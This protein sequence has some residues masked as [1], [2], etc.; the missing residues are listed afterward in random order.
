MKT[1]HLLLFITIFFLTF[2][3]DGAIEQKLLSI[4]TTTLFVRESPS[5]TA[6]KLKMLANGTIV[7]SLEEKEHNENIDWIK[8]EYG[9]KEN[10]IR[11]WIA[12]QYTA[13]AKKVHGLPNFMHDYP[14]M[15]K[16]HKFPGNPPVKVRGIYLSM[17]SAMRG[18][19]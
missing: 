1:L 5:T 18:R 9:V 6:K 15:E 16:D 2:V 4:T 19:L 11:G 3:A 14:A 12:A 13:P 7:V 8:I 17:F 10:K